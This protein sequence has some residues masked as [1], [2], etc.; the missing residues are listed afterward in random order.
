MDK[1]YIDNYIIKEVQYFLETP[2]GIGNYKKEF[3]EEAFNE[4]SQEAKEKFEADF[5]LNHMAT[6]KCPYG[7]IGKITA[8]CSDVYN[9]VM[10]YRR[11]NFSIYKPFTEACISR[12]DYISFL[13]GLLVDSANNLKITVSSQGN[14]REGTCKDLENAFEHSELSEI[15][16]AINSWQ[17]N[18]KGYLYSLDGVVDFEERS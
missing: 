2:D 18:K 7:Y 9:S 10:A 5:A 16:I 14:T 1:D 17:S 15:K 3:F 8:V 6:A 11:G 13:Q 12:E 4:L